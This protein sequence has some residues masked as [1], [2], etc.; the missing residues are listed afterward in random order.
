[1]AKSKPRRAVA[2]LDF[3]V[4]LALFLATLCPIGA[5]AQTA[6]SHAA[7][8][9]AVGDQIPPSVQLDDDG[10]PDR[11]YGVLIVDQA[12]VVVVERSTRRV[13]EIH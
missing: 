6:Q 13:V 7:K 5:D 11:P 1:M 3:T 9:Y 2:S 12:I 8:S 4:G 10:F